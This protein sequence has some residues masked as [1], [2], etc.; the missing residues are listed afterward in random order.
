MMMVPTGHANCVA[1]VYKQKNLDLDCFTGCLKRG[2]AG[3]RQREGPAGWQVIVEESW[4]VLMC[5]CDGGS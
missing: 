2:C 4:K 3:W 1:I 5:G